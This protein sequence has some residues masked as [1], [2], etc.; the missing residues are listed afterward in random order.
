M[1]VEL[2]LSGR[3][4]SRKI[5]VIQCRID[6]VVIVILQVGRLDATRNR[7]PAVKEKDF[8]GVSLSLV[9]SESTSHQIDLSNFFASFAESDLP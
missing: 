5:I 7:M 9:D 8:H 4:R 1:I 3:N 6:D 2:G